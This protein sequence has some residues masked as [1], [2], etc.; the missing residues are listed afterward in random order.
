VEL[1]Q[2]NIRVYG[3]WICDGKVMVSH[4]QSEDLRFTKFPGGGLEMGEGILHCLKREFREEL[5]IEF[6]KHSLFYVTEDLV[7]SAFN[8]EE[9]LVSVYYQ[10]Q[11][12]QEP[13]GTYL[14]EMRWGKKY[15][16]QLAWLPLQ[17][18]KESMFHFPVDK[19][20]ARMLMAEASL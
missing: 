15:T 3:I 18:I 2:F 17:D 10:V 12:D 11:S 13:V 7:I 14:E 9:Q 8:Q 4:E 1:K 20:V 16:I 6:Q 19:T 5:G